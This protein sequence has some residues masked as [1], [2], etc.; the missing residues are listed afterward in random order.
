MLKTLLIKTTFKGDDDTQW[1]LDNLV[2][3]ILKDIKTNKQWIYISNFWLELCEISP[4]SVIKRVESEWDKDT[5]LLS[6]FQNQSSDYL[7]ESKPYIAILCGVE[8]LLLQKKFVWRTFRWFLKLDSKLVQNET[9]APK[10]TLLKVFCTSVA[11][12]L[13]M[14]KLKL[15]ELLLKLMV[16]KRGDIC[17]LQLITK[18]KMELVNCLRQNIVNIANYKQLQ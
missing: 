5:G 12:S 6:L 4:K 13:R 15:H 1:H 16:I 3:T 14:R 9:N 11:Y 17:L 7:F 2:E 8:Q 10:N 18:V